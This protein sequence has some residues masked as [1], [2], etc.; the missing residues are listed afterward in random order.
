MRSRYAAYV[1]KLENYLLKTWHRDTRPKSL[2]LAND[3]QTR[4]LGLE[5][6]R[7]VITGDSTAM[8]EFIARYKIGGKA[9]RLHESSDF[10]QIDHQWYYID[11]HHEN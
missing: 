1:L 11:G 10:I 6:K 9:G 8:V 5:V 4:W 2:D 7:H 3:V